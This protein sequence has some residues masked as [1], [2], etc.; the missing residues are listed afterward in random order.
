MS[1]SLA[2]EKGLPFCPADVREQLAEI[3]YKQARI[4][5]E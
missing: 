5:C 1:S 3:I 4:G 2:E